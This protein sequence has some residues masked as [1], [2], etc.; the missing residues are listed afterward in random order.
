M[1]GGNGSRPGVSAELTIRRYI[2]VLSG[3]YGIIYIKSVVLVVVLF[4]FF[5]AELY[6]YGGIIC[7]L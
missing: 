4:H 1:A 6:V 3:N 5:R 7:G 2:S